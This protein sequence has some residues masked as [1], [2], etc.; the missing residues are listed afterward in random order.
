MIPNKFTRKL[1]LPVSFDVK[2]HRG[3]NYIAIFSIMFIVF[4]L[5]TLFTIGFIFSPRTLLVKLIVIPIWYIVI[6]FYRYIVF[7]EGKMSDNFELQKEKDF[8]TPLT[9]MWAAYDID[10]KHPYVVH[11][12]NNYK[13]VFVRFKKDVIQGKVDNIEFE[14]YNAIAN[15]YQKAHDLGLNLIPIDY[16]DNVGNDNRLDALYSNTERGANP[17]LE[18]M[19]LGVYSN[20]KNLMSQEFSSFDVVLI[21]MR[22]SPDD[23]WFR[24]RQVLEEYKDAN[25]KSF[26]L[27]NSTELLTLVKELYN[28]EDFSIYEAEKAVL[29][30]RVKQ[31]LRPIT[32][33]DVEGK[34]TQL[35]KT[36]EEEEQEKQ[37]LQ[38]E[39]RNKR[40]QKGSQT[41]E[42]SQLR[43]EVETKQAEYRTEEV[44]QHVLDLF[45][46]DNVSPY[47]ALHEQ[48]ESGF[49]T[50]EDLDAK[51]SNDKQIHAEIWMQQI[52]ENDKEAK[53]NLSKELDL[54]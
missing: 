20:L 16:M 42:A 43:S 51:Q 19:L 4:I 23:L 47:A 10:D 17:E 44:N 29:D 24:V 52:E 54:F 50:Q 35:N 9:E 28:L 13:G 3:K 32:L 18:N 53:E 45:S 39:A 31:I 15:A 49:I 11:Y 34:V 37:R 2:E 27:L 25:Y 38:E 1:R 21:Y 5:L 14:H 46:T 6:L 8:K 36:F 33:I 22:T 7:K 41:K 48:A 30:T 40:Q 26:E 12:M